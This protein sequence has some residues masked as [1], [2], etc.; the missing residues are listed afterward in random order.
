MRRRL[1]RRLQPGTTDPQGLSPAAA[2]DDR[3]E[4]GEGDR[5]DHAEED[6]IGEGGHD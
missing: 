6:G 1:R 5:H 2:P 3:G 4:R